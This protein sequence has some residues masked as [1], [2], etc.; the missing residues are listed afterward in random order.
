MWETPLGEHALRAKASAFTGADAAGTILLERG[1]A[2]HDYMPELSASLSLPGANRTY[3]PF[4]ERDG[5]PGWSGRLGGA[6]WD[7]L[8]EL[9]GGY[10]DNNGDINAR[11]SAGAV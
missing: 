11:S 4:R 10:W 2:L 1:W 3:K 5:R 6:L 9:E 7:R 8:V